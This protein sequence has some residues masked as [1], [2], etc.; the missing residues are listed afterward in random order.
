MVIKWT[1]KFSNETGFVKKINK[2]AGYFE[3]TFDESEAKSFTKTTGEKALNDLPVLC[4]D[5]TY[6]LI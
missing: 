4:D 5:N 1:N 6:E 2:K 3:N